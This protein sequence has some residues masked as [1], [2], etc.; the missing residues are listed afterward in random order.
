MKKFYKGLYDGVDDIKEFR[1]EELFRYRSALIKRSIDEANFI[2]KWLKDDKNVVFDIGCG[3]GR[4]YF[5]LNKK[6]K[7]IDYYGVDISKSRISFAKRWANDLKITNALFYN[8]DFFRENIPNKLTAD[9]VLVLTGLMNYFGYTKE[10]DFFLKKLKNHLKKGSIVI[11]ELFNKVEI[12]NKLK[13]K[14]QSYRIWVEFPSSDR[15]RFGLHEFSLSGRTVIDKKKHIKRDLSA[16]DEDRIEYIYI[17]K[18][19]EIENILNRF[20]FSVK[21]V[22]SSFLFEKYVSNQVNE[23]RIIVAEYRG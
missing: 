22:Y 12:R 3:N 16:I 21:E 13:D 5:C 2:S 7:N 11:F 19:E 1:Q 15:Y 14:D 17:Y 8:L 18:D 6:G 23:L 4:I 20:G 9:I 10:Y